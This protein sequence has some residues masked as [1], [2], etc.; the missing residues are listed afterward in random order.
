AQVGRLR[1][2]R[3]TPTVSVTHDQVDA[4][5]PG[6]RVAVMRDGILQQV[7]TPHNLYGNPSN[8][9]VAAFIGSPP[10]NLIE[11]KVSDG[12]VAFA[13]FEVPMP[14]GSDLGGRT[15]ILGIRPSDLEDA[16]VWSNPDLPTIEVTADVTEELGSEV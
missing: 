16:A 1:D 13:G 15:L 5:T 11:A 14:D 9:F 12:R 6:E 7:D 2:P 10:M 4:M 8:L 3:E